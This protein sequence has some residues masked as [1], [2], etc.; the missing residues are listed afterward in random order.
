[1]SKINVNP[2][3]FWLH[4]WIGNF[5]VGKV[6]GERIMRMYFYVLQTFKFLRIAKWV[7]GRLD[8]LTTVP[9]QWV[10]TGM[11]KHW[12]QAVKTWT[13]KDWPSSIYLAGQPLQYVSPWLLPVA[14][15]RSQPMLPRKILRHGGK[16]HWTIQWMRDSTLLGKPLASE[17]IRFQI[18]YDQ[19]YYVTKTA[20]NNEC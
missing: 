4:P 10:D 2:Q 14:G 1:M 18:Y 3:H 16:A 12:Y 13:C 17:T 20:P 7:F 19:Y 6:S 15:F 8:V 5:S 11:H 9:S